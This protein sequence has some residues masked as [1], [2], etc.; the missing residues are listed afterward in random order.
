MFSFVWRIPA[1]LGVELGNLTLPFCR[2]ARQVGHSS[3]LVQSFVFQYKAVLGFVLVCVYVCMCIE[4]WDSVLPW[5]KT[6]K[7]FDGKVSTMVR[8]CEAIYIYIY[9]H[10]KHIHTH[11]CI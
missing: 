4:S 8:Y 1:V 2:L 10:I 3:G 9:M 6:N 11:I 5:D 7:H